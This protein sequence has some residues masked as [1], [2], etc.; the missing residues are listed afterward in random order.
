ME[1]MRES[2]RIPPKTAF[3]QR[4]IQL[5]FDVGIALNEYSGYHYHTEVDML[6]DL[7]ARIEATLLTKDKE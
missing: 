7:A 6:H 3:T 1:T 2:G 4:D 5:L